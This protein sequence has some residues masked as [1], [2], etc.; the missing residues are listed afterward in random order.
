MTKSAEAGASEAGGP[1]RLG[2]WLALL[3]RLIGNLATLALSGLILVLLANV[4]GRYLFASS[5]AW[6]QEAAI[7]LFIYIIF[8]GLPRAQRRERHIALTFLVDRLPP[9]WRAAAAILAD[10]MLGYVTIMLLF[11]AL[12]LMQR[13]GGTS[14][15]LLLPIWLKF[16]FIPVGCAASLLFLVFKGSEQGDAPWRGALA[17]L[18]ALL[19]YLLWQEPG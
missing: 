6:A 1:S 15:A 9:R 4:T 19:F 11:A 12:E 2:R 7:W 17:L 14:P 3:D 18:L 8:L 13:I 16:I 5:L 10:A